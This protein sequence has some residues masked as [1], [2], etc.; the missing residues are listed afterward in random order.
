MQANHS[1][2][3]KQNIRR[4]DNMFYLMAYSEP[5]VGFTKDILKVFMVLLSI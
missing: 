4:Y 5:H 3:R 1:D 2:N